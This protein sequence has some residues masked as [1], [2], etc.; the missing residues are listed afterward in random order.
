MSLIAKDNGGDKDFSPIPA[1]MHHAVC[2]AVVDIGT[3]PQVGQFPARRKIVITWEI[4]GETIEVEKNGKNV[5]IPR[6]LS[7]RYTL[8]LASKGNLRPMLESWRGRAFTSEELAGFDLKSL[9]GA[10]CLINVIHEKGRGEKADK[11]YANVASVSPLMKGTAKLTPINPK[12]LFSLDDFNGTI[13]DDIPNWIAKLINESKEYL[14]YGQPAP[15]KGGT[16]PVAAEEV[17]DDDAM[18]F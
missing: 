18:P 2:Y 12:V 11:T 13:S 15:V 9:V 17:A 7:G 1:G 14:A 5:V 4:P 16:T 3:Q 8:S 10:N 6:A